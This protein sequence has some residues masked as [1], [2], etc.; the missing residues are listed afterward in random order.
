MTKPIQL[1]IDDIK[2]PTTTHDRYQSYPE[3]LR[4][5]LQMADG[6]VVEEVV[7]TVQRIRY[8][9]DKMPDPIYKE[10][11]RAVRSGGLKAVSYL[12]DD[13]S[14]ELVTGEFLVESIQQPTLQFYINKEPMWHNFGFTLREAKPHA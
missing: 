2:C 5:L 6:T 7:G 10:L 8:S 12:P 11:S 13:G 14:V 1:I 3:Q 4:E 9:Y